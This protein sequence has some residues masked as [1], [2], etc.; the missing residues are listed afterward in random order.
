MSLLRDGIIHFWDI[1]TSFNLC[2]VFGGRNTI[3]KN[4]VNCELCLAIKNKQLDCNHEY[5]YKGYTKSGASFKFECSKCG[6][7]IIELIR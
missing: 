6:K 1:K 4:N 3:D 5:K 7:Q 2:E